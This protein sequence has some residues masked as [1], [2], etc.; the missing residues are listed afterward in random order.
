MPRASRITVTCAVCPK[1]WDLPPSRARQN[2]SN[3]CSEECRRKKI[4][5]SKIELHQSAER[6]VATCSTCGGAFERKPSQ[7]AKYASNY[8]SRACK[9]A[10]VVANAATAARL[11]NGAEFPCGHCGTPVW[12]TPGTLHGHVFCSMLCTKLGQWRDRSPRVRRVRLACP[13]CGAHRTVLPGWARRMRGYCSLQCRSVGTSGPGNY[14][15]RGG[16][17]NRPYAP[18]F[19]ERLKLQIAKRDGFR[20]MVCGLRR[21]KGTHVVHHL[22]W[23]KHDHHPDNLVLLCRPCHGRHHAHGEPHFRQLATRPIARN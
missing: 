19:T 17:A 11:I 18:G 8:C 9:A 14:N 20:C 16:S 6:R 12:R 10:D 23:Q 21:G 13:T 7:L 5:Q 3:V 1:T 2:K 22:D 15:W 4:S